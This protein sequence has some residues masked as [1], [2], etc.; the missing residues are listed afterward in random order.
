VRG[1][2][3]GE[4]EFK[5]RGLSRETVIRLQQGKAC[6]PFSLLLRWPVLLANQCRRGI[7]GSARSVDRAR[8]EN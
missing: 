8:P 4:G 7:I 3:D 5:G 2:K 6:R 1:K